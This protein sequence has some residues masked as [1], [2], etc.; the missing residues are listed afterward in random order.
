MGKGKQWVKWR[1]VRG[2]VT[3]WQI[4]QAKERTKG[5]IQKRARRAEELR[6]GKHNSQCARELDMELGRYKY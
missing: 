1:H 6:C 3:G 2:S 4:Y 5:K